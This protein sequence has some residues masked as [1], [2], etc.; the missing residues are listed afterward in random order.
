MFKIGCYLILQAPFISLR[1]IWEDTNRSII[2]HR[3]LWLFLYARLMSA[4]FSLMGNF[5]EWIES[6]ILSH[7]HFAKKSTFFFNRFVLISSFCGALFGSRFWKVF[8]ISLILI[9]QNLKTWE[10]L[11]ALIN[12]ILGLSLHLPIIIK[13]GSCSDECGHYIHYLAYL[14]MGCL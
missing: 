4:C 3:K 5:E 13:T 2:F 7:V 14:K 9:W 1:N 10:L 11:L 8:L 6:L 12:L